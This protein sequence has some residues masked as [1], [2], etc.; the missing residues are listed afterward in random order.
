MKCDKCRKE[1]EPDQMDAKPYAGPLP[2][3]QDLIDASN[4]L[5]WDRLECRECY[6]DG[7]T[8]LTGEL[9]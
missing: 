9:L 6:G 8:S 5:D 2:T 3:G 4:G 1:F 7:F